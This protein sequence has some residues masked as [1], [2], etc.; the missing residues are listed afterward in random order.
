MSLTWKQLAL[1][2]VTAVAAS[3][4]SCD[5]AIKAPVESTEGE[6][7]V[8]ADG[9]AFSRSALLE[10]FGSCIVS[11]L[12]NFKEQ[13]RS[14]ASV[15]AAAAV[16]PAQRE[17]AQEAWRTT[18]DAWQQLEVMQVGPAG[19][20]TQPGGQGWRDTFI[21]TWPLND[22]CAIDRYLVSEE[23]SSDT[24][25]V[26][27]TANGLAAAEYLLF[28]SG[29]A[30]FCE[31]DDEIN[32]SGSWDMV[33]GSALTSRRASY[34]AFAAETVAEAANALFNA[35][36]PSG[37]NFVAELAQAGEGSRTYGKKRVA[38]N[39]LSDALFYIEWNTKDNKLARPLGL[40]GCDQ[41]LCPELVESRYGRRSKEHLRN[42]II[43]FRK[44][45][46]GCGPDNEG[47]GFDDFLY[48]VGQADLA[49]E[50]DRAA[51]ATI[52]AI[53]A[54]DEADLVTAL[55]EDAQSVSEVHSALRQLTDLL[56]S[57][58]LIVLSL[59]LPQMVQSD[60]D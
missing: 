15:A 1:V 40:I 41:D 3:T 11:E 18:I 51:L 23:Y 10:A 14:F 42:N 29:N 32:V 35:W 9:T 47:L 38:V 39:A 49:E 5:Q 16:E 58:F 22:Y 30:N 4:Y 52:E 27:S 12:E 13:S 57:E 34:A 8:L 24:G 2:A 6:D 33:A 48:A 46:V 45:F 36:S 7:A 56:R 43:G 44:L 25:E 26:K 37:E 53:D 19:K 17:A 31:A 60:N 55:A 20:S 28:Y 21:Y 59:E 50:I 54:I